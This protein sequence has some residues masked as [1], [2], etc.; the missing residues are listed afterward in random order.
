MQPQEAALEIL[1]DLVKNDPVAVLG[2]CPFCE[3]THSD[4]CPWARAKRLVVQGFYSPDWPEYEKRCIHCGEEVT[5]RS[6]VH[7]DCAAKFYESIA[8]TVAAQNA[9]LAPVLDTLAPI[10]AMWKRD[11]GDQLTD[12]PLFISWSNEAKALRDAYDRWQAQ[13]EVK[14]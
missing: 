11:G 6:S 2:E 4:S 10:I 3:G 9:G 1:R 12:S 7:S 14:P 8:C 5:A 13:K